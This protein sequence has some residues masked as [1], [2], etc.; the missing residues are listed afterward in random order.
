MKTIVANKIHDKQIYSHLACQLDNYNLLQ[1]K[2][3]AYNLLTVVSDLIVSEE[4]LI[5][6]A[7]LYEEK[8]ESQLATEDNNLFQN[9]LEKILLK[10]YQKRFYFFQFKFYIYYLYFKG[11]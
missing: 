7:D 11:L 1:M 4:L 5:K 6:L 3:L 10:N 8:Q 2:Y 9:F